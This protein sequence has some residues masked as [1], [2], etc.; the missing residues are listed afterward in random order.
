MTKIFTVD[1]AAKKVGVSKSTFL[2]RARALDCKFQKLG[3]NYVVP[4]E[5][6]EKV[7]AYTPPAPAKRSLPTALKI[8]NLAR[9]KAKLEMAKPRLNRMLDALAKLELLLNAEIKSLEKDQQ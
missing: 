2:Q 4:E 9:K 1:S 5:A 6:I 8:K 3:K 7:R